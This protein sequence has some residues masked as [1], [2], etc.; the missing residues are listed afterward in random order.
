MRHLRA[1]GHGYPRTGP[2]E[3]NAK[4]D[5]LAR[6]EGLVEP[7]RQ[8]GVPL[9]QGGD[10]TEPVLAPSGPMVL[11]Q[12]PTPIPVSR[13]TVQ[14]GLQADIATLPELVEEVAQRGVRKDDV[15]IHEGNPARTGLSYAHA[16]GSRDAP[17]AVRKDAFSVAAGDLERPIRRSSIDDDDSVGPWRATD[18]RHS[19]RKGSAFRTGTTTEIGSGSVPGTTSGIIYRTK[20][21][22]SANRNR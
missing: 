8:E 20:P 6:E 22:I 7:D 18:A 5:I 16:A 21:M 13:H 19:S 15:G 4:L 3:A 11:D 10:Q 2:L 12:G 17:T 9:E 1:T 14:A